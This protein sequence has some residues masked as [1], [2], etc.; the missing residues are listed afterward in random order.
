MSTIKELFSQ[1]TASKSKKTAILF[2]AASMTKTIGTLAG[3]ILVLRWVEPSKIGLWQSLMIAS[4]YSSI[5]QFGIMSGLNRELPYLIGAGKEEE[6]KNLAAA[7]QGY[8]MIL[9]GVTIL[10]AV[11]V[12]FFYGLLNGI[13]L[14]LQLGILGV[15]MIIALG[16]Y[17]N[18]LAVTF[19]AEK[20]FQR[21]SKVYF[22]QFFIAIASLLFVYYKNYYGLILYYVTC[23]SAL[24]YSMHRVRPVRIKPTWNLFSLKK[25]LKTGFPIFGLSYLQ[26]ISKSFTRII[27]LYTGTTLAVG[28]FAPATAIQTAMV[29]LPGIMAQYLYPKMS[30]IYGKTND[31]RKLWNIVKTITIGFLIFSTTI[32][33]PAW[34]ALPVLIEKFFPKY[35]EG[36]FA[37]QLTLIS[38]VF[39]GTLISMNALY[40]VKAFKPML[41]ITI[42]QLLLFFLIPFI[43]IQFF[44]PLDGVAIGNLIAS[45]IVFLFSIW[46]MFKSLNVIETRDIRIK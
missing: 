14:S 29:M 7:A 35:I 10:A 2:S 8:A 15:G 46:I 37:A 3:G 19:R 30:F 16:F 42:L 27:L 45:F 25:L 9:V 24:T 28:L 38:A 23:E 20:T 5:L 31:K 41:K 34:F 17:H 36:I 32:S 1:V 40:S 22:I 11:L 18:Y 12:T 26:Q 39:T 33:I 43:M 21:L 4:T 6:G 13:N 44:N